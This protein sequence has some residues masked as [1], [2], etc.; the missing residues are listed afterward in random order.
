MKRIELNMNPYFSAKFRL[1][2][3]LAFTASIISSSAVQSAPIQNEI[4]KNICNHFL[5]G[6][7][8]YS[9]DAQ[10][11]SPMKSEPLLTRLYTNLAFQN[12]FINKPLRNIT[13]A[14][15]NFLNDHE[16]LTQNRLFSKLGRVSSYYDAEFDTR[17]YHSLTGKPLADGSVPVVDPNSKGLYIY[18]HG[19]GTNKASGANFAYK[20]NELSKLGYSALSF[21]L[22]FHADG[23]QNHKVA[24]T[25]KFMT[26]LNRMIEK[27]R[28]PGKP[29]YLA[30]HSFGPELIFEYVKRY[31]FSL[32]GAV[33]L[34]PAAFNDELN[35]WFLKHTS[36]ATAFW[37]DTKPSNLGGLWG[38][39]VTGETEWN[40]LK[41]KIPD[42][43]LVNPKLKLIAM[44]GDYEEYVPGPVLPNGEPAKESRT[45]S[46][47]IELKKF[48]ANINCYLEPKVGHYIFTHKDHYGNDVVMRELLRVTQNKEDFDSFPERMSSFIKKLKADADELKPSE[49]DKVSIR[50]Q[51]D[52]F[53]KK[54]MNETQGGIAS[55]QKMILD[56]NQREAQM[57]SKRFEIILKQRENKLLENIFAS[58][59]TAPLFYQQNKEIFDKTFQ[60]DGSIISG[61]DSIVAAYYDYLDQLPL[62]KRAAFSANHDVY[63]LKTD[64]VIQEENKPK[65]TTPE[66]THFTVATPSGLVIDFD[67]NLAPTDTQIPLTVNAI[68]EMRNLQLFKEAQPLNEWLRKWVNLVYNKKTKELESWSIKQ[69]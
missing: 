14:A 3:T 12:G 5:I 30:G 8:E 54:W 15:P 59:T 10:V 37:G 21:D 69:E 13:E 16:F 31:P 51:R 19:S 46:V 11:K 22:P 1:G 63:E 9:A 17:I 66:S 68:K 53:F 34:S 56:G 61:T 65:R 60:E 35:E 41:S 49:I 55:I 42:P 7:K 67:L 26:Q 39:H 48:F 33:A 64:P 43:T 20:T 58:K 45:Y 40:N 6:N 36:Q 38:G 62:E 32:D 24:Q 18:I 44:T 4:L 27:F 23:S 50:Y 28:I 2:M 57:I 25:E 47:C 52:P 29:V